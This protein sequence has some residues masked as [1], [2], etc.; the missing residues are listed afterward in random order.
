MMTGDQYPEHW[1]STRMRWYIMRDGDNRGKRGRAYTR[2]EGTDGGTLGT[3]RKSPGV[4]ARRNG[5][6]LPPCRRRCRRT[7]AL[8][9]L[10]HGHDVV[11]NTMRMFPGLNYTVRALN[12]LRTA[13]EQHLHAFDA[14]C[15]LTRRLPPELQVYTTNATNDN[16]AFCTCA[17]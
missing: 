5:G 14:R 8:L 3:S 2:K 6:N 16:D 10:Q 7:R 12:H 17:P 1:Y 13:P 4:K 15:Q 11:L 9:L